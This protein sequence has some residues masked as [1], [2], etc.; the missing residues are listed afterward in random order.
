MNTDQFTQEIRLVSAGDGPWEWIGGAFFFDESLS[1]NY[2]F[3]D[4]SPFG[5]TFLNGGNLDT[6]SYAAFGQLGYDFRKS[7][8]P[9]KV[10]GGLR[11]TQDE[12]QIYEYQA[13]PT[14]G[15][16]RDDN[17][18][19]AWD[20]VTGNIEAEYFV[21]DDVMTYVRLS[22]GYKGGGYSMGQFDKYN[23][24]KMDSVEAGMKSQFW[25]NRAQI[26]IAAFYNE[27]KD[28]QVNFLEFTTFR[29]EN[30]AEAT[31]KGVEFESEFI[32]F[33]HLTVGANVSWL[34]AEYDDFIFSTD[35]V[36]IDLSGDTLNRAP[37]YTTQ[38]FVQ[39]DWGLGDR[40]TVTAR[41]DYYWQDDVYYRLQNIE[42]HEADAF[43]TAD[44]RVMW[45]SA[46]DRW[47]V[48][49]F[50][51]NLTDEDNLRNM[52]VSDGLSTGNNSFESYYPPRTY[53]VRVGFRIGD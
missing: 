5:F 21:S 39:Y 29:T 28:L 34:S 37:K 49:T 14:F 41:A 31:I 43:Y 48:D 3:E 27:Y 11:Y 13:I 18:N 25:N 26:N 45:T 42:R 51:K 44:A 36:L 53:G 20:Q 22:H 16:N 2:M 30:A 50:V 4:S 46:G 33:D 17:N 32:P 7:G 35:P 23:P 10:V 8:H 15:L 12:K 24:E 6:R 40:G 9:F 38:L 47:V 52:T 19:E 1:T